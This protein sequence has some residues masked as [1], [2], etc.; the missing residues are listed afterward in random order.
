MALPRTHSRPIRVGG[1]ALR[2]MFRAQEDGPVGFRLIVAA[3]QGPRL[4]VDFPGGCGPVSMTP[5]IVAHAVQQALSAG[6]NPHAPG[7][8][9]RLT[10]DARDLPARPFRHK[11][12]P[13][14]EGYDLGFTVD[15]WPIRCRVPWPHRRGLFSTFRLDGQVTTMDMGSLLAS[16]VTPVLDEPTGRFPGDWDKVV[17][18]P[19]LLPGGMKLTLHGEL[20]IRPGC[21]CGLEEW[22][23]WRDLARD[24]GS[25]WNGHEPFSTAIARLDEGVIEFR[26]AD[27]RTQ[28]SGRS[29]VVS[30]D[31]YRRIVAHTEADL[32]GFFAVWETFLW[33]VLGDRAPT[34]LAWTRGMAR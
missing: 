12:H 6:W 26:G 23:T 25:T 16:L 1:H 8:P 7:P 30:L 29:A 14:T 21:C 27:A 19:V 34:V 11:D 32:H 10:H 24:G 5:G 28:P 18:S 9:T 15:L 3:A 17:A 4:E 2:W 33:E 22:P 31:L 13:D 20:V